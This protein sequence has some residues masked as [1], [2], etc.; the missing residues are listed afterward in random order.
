MLPLVVVARPAVTGRKKLD[1]P[2]SEKL[3]VEPD[4]VLI[5]APD[6]SVIVAL[7]LVPVVNAE[8]DRLDDP[9]HDP[10]IQLP[11]PEA[12]EIKH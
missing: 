10:Q 4:T 3:T 9:E 5:V 6:P 1:T 11:A 8:N 2:V 12:V 7:V